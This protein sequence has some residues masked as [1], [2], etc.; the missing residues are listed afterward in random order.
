MVEHTTNALVRIADNLANMTAETAALEAVHKSLSDVR[1]HIVNIID[2]ISRIDT[3]EPY[4]IEII[5]AIKNDLDD[6]I[7]S[8][9]QSPADLHK[10]EQRYGRCA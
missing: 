4:A 7:N 8:P 6:V 5:Q 9:A 2:A 1:G 3:K 10:P